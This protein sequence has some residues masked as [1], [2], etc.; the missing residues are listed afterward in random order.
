MNLNDM[1]TFVREHAD[2]D[3]SDAPSSNLTVYARAAYNDIRRRT[4]QWLDN[5]A[6]DTL[7]TTAGQ[8][9]YVMSGSGFTSANIEYVTNVIASDGPVTFVPYETFL[10][11]QDGSTGGTSTIPEYFSVRHNTVYLYPAP[12]AS[13]T[14]FTVKG[15]RN[16]ADWPNVSPAAEPDLPRE[17]DEAICWSMLSR[18]YMGQED[19]ELAQLYEN[20]YET[21]V[22]RQIAAMMINDGIKVRTLGGKVPVGRMTYSSWVR[23]MTEG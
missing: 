10:Q 4:Y 23:R 8:A 21:A 2:T 1:I 5:V 6:D 9:S 20:F 18:Y 15:Y 13:G 14:T 16:F 17:F 7:T 3:E 11:L 22:G 19:I 12:S